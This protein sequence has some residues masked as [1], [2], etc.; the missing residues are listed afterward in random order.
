MRVNHLTGM[1]VGGSETALF[2]TIL[3]QWGNVCL[4]AESG[5]NAAVPETEIRLP[6]YQ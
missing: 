2:C 6:D 1:V 4:H 3:V 5:R